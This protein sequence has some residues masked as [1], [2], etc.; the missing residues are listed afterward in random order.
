MLKGLKGQNRFY[1]PELLYGATEFRDPTVYASAESDFLLI[2]LSL[3]CQKAM[4]KAA[5]TWSPR[6]ACM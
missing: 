1:A 2:L 3:Y 5:E 4:G 6:K